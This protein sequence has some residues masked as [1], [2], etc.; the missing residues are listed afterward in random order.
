MYQMPVKAIKNILTKELA[1]F[2]QNALYGNP[3]GKNN[4]R[5]C[6]DATKNIFESGYDLLTARLDAC[7]NH[8]ALDSFIGEVYRM[9]LEDWINSL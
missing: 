4:I 5:H 1:E 2:R 6:N 9:S 8:E 3:S 7:N